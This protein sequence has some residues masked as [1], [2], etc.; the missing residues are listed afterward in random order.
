MPTAPT[1]VSPPQSL[2]TMLEDIRDETL[3]LVRDRMPPE[4]RALD[5]LVR[6]DSAHTLTA[7]LRTLRDQGRAMPLSA[8]QVAAASRERLA[9]DLPPETNLLG[10]M[11]ATAQMIEDMENT[12]YIP[13]RRLL[14]RLCLL[15]EAVRIFALEEQAGMGAGQRGPLAPA[16]EY[17][18]QLPLTEATFIQDCLNQ[19][20][21][22]ARAKG[23]HKALSDDTYK[24]DAKP[25]SAEEQKVKE[26]EARLR[27]GKEGPSEEEI[28]EAERAFRVRGGGGDPFFDRV[29]IYVVLS[30]QQPILYCLAF[31]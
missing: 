22:Q 1:H 13:D 4:L 16:L 29:F 11:L 12:P 10:L 2:V 23:V 5:Q 24:V 9:L 19:R 30:I 20:N 15:R 7:V 21:A 18:E 3:G 25:K 14:A 26:L 27:K 6:L 28:Q 31:P 17:R 8:S